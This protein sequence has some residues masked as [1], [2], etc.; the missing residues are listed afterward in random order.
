MAEERYGV[1]GFP[2]SI[3][4]DNLATF[5]PQVGDGAIALYVALASFAGNTTRECWPSHATLAKMLGV[6]TMTIMR[7]LK[8]L[9]EANLI[10]VEHRHTDDGRQTSNLYH[11]SNGSPQSDSDVRGEGNTD[12]RV[13]P[14]PVLDKLDLDELS[15]S[16]TTE[17]N[18]ESRDSP[19]RAGPPPTPTSFEEWLERIR[20]S[21]NRTA[22]LR[23]MYGVLYPRHELPDY[24]KIGRAAKTLGG[25]SRLAAALWENAIRPPTGCVLQYAMG[26]HKRKQKRAQWRGKPSQSDRIA[27]IEAWAA[28]ELGGS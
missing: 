24:G 12:V 21:K 10:T 20:E 5:A 13:T 8:R 1:V 28:Q 4:P 27:E 19:D 16:R 11:L 14:T 22:L 6:T 7:R 25:A 9:E 3:I 26:A 15:P 2:F 18:G 23:H 17:N